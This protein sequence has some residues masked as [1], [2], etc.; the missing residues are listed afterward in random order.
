MHNQLC[1]G[2]RWLAEFCKFSLPHENVVRKYLSWERKTPIKI[3]VHAPDVI[4]GG[5]GV[6]TMVGKILSFIEA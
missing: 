5:A 3:K 4:L 6:R 1:L 2:T